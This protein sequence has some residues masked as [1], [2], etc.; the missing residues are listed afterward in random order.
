MTL[1]ISLLLV[2]L[3]SVVDVHS[4]C[5]DDRHT[6]NY[7]DAWI[8]CETALSP[9]PEDTEPSHWI[10][11]DIGVVDTLYQVHIWNYNHWENTNYG[12]SQLSISLSIDGETWITVDTFSID[13]SPGSAYY[14]G[15][16][17]AN[18]GGREA[19]YI[20]F[21]ALDNYGGDCYALSEIKI[22]LEDTNYCNDKLAVEVLL[23]PNIIGSS[24]DIVL[25]TFVLVN[26]GDEAIKNIALFV[27]ES[28]L[29]GEPHETTITPTLQSDPNGNGQLDVG[30][31]WF[32]TAV[33]S[34]DYNEG[35]IFIVSAGASGFGNTCQVVT[36]NAKLLF[37]TFNPNALMSAEEQTAYREGLGVE[38]AELIIYPNPVRQGA[39]LF[40]ENSF[41]QQTDIDIYNQR[42]QIV[43]SLR[44][45]TNQTLSK[46]DTKML[47]SGLYFC[48]LKSHPNSKPIPFMILE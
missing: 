25:I 43:R 17:I 46:L 32:Y 3:L 35:D 44:M 9:N 5:F 7:T 6:L 40:I 26:T 45:E 19:R 31:V 8:S 11:Y 34:F 12:I 24:S 23:S 47:D 16:L 4:Q 39:E 38:A 33:K 36:G 30:E 37:T 28:L 20:L 29:S 15:Q 27:E 21:S 13:E 10:M 1:R 48:K 22:R 41:G 14:E 42:G 18:I 2:S